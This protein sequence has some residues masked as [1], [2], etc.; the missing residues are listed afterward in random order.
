MYVMTGVHSCL[1]SRVAEFHAVPL[2]ERLEANGRP[3]PCRGTGQTPAESIRNDYPRYAWRPCKREPLS[4]LPTNPLED[5][6]RS[7]ISARP[8][9]RRER[10]REEDPV[11]S[12]QS[13]SPWS[14]SIG[15]R[16]RKGI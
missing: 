3:F 7:V 2:R 16:E 9:E 4:G 1:S 11:I 13:M 6:C 5:S 14:K 8:D 12:D 10:A 15:P